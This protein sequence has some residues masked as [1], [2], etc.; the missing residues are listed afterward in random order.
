MDGKEKKIMALMLHETRS[1]L[2]SIIV[3]HNLKA[4]RGVHRSATRISVDTFFTFLVRG[5]K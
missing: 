3:S 1:K 2:L 5:L 4:R